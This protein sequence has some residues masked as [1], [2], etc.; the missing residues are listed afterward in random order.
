MSKLIQSC[1]KRGVSTSHAWHWPKRLFFGLAM[2]LLLPVSINVAATPFCGV[3]LNHTL[4]DFS[5]CGGRGG[6]IDALNDTAQLRTHAN[7]LGAVKTKGC[8]P[9]CEPHMHRAKWRTIDVGQFEYNR[10][11]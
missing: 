6:S 5:H 3:E 8:M 1:A 10:E 4:V 7:T 2:V 11:R 9:T